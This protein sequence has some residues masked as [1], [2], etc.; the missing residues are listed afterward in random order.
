MEPAL[1]GVSRARQAHARSAHADLLGSR[2]MRIIAPPPFPIPDA[3]G[4]RP[5]PEP[6]PRSATRIWLLRH[7]EVHADWHA[8]AYGNTDVPLSE[9]GEQQT[10]AL[11][12]SFSGLRLDLVVSSQLVRARAM[13]EAI[14]RA[15]GAPLAIDERLREIWRGEWQGLPASEFRRGWDLER[16]AFLADPWHRKGPPGESEADA[17]R[18]PWPARRGGLRPARG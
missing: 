14:A 4:Q 9:A 1:Y 18:P 8:R 2:A 13:G 6:G 12:S 16:E 15:S 7:A 17:F 10:R 11:S 5:A 3:A